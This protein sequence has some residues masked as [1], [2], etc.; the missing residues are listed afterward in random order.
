M[1]PSPLPRTEGEPAFAAVYLLDQPYAIDRAFDY[2][3][4]DL[5][6]EDIRRG[7][8]VTVP[9]GAGNKTKIGLVTG[10][11]DSTDAK[12]IKPIDDLLAGSMALDEEMTDLCLRLAETTLSTV[13]DAVRAAVPTFALGSVTEH[14]APVPGRSYS[15]ADE[16]LA[17]IYRT[18]TECGDLTVRR[19]RT[20]TGGAI[21]TAALT[22]LCRKLTR[23]GYF[24]CT[25]TP[26]AAHLGTVRR[27]YRLATDR[28]TAVLLSNGEGAGATR[29]RSSAHREILRCFLSLP[30]GTELPE[31]FFTGGEDGTTPPR[32]YSRPQL[33]ALTEKDLLSVREEVVFRDPVRPAASEPKEY[34][35]NDEQAAALGQLVRM[36]DDK[37]A[38]AA[39]LHG[40][41]GSGK[42]CVMTGILDHILGGGGGAIL[43][44]PEISLT[45][46]TLSIF[47][48]RYGEKVAVIHS[49]LSQGERYDAYRRIREG[50]ATLVI[51]TRS[52]VFAPVRNLRL[53]IMDEEQEH[54][55]KSDRDPKYHARDVARFRCARNNALLLLAS[56]TPTLETYKKALD[57]TYTLLRLTKR[58]HDVPLPEV[59]IADMK[60]EVSGQSVTP[61]GNELLREM[62]RVKKN[63]EQSLL[64]LNRRG[65][66]R[67]LSCR[68]CGKPVLC[69]NC[70][71]ALTYHT[72]K[73]TFE[74]GHLVCHLCG[75]R[76]PVPSVCPSCSSEH[77]ARLGFGTQRIEKDLSD[78][79]PDARILRMDADSTS[80]KG[81]YD[82]MLGAFRR[83]E[84][85]ILLGT[86]MV[87]KGH[88]FPDVTLVGVLNAD[89]SMFA[90]DYRAAEHTFSMLTQ[91]I[92]RA[93]RADKP[94][95][96]IIQ[97]NNPDA[98]VIRY[99]VTQDY[100]RFY[101]N[102]IRLRRELTF[103]PFCDMVLLTVTAEE[104][105]AVL[106]AAL[107]CRKE[108]DRMTAS[109]G[110]YADVKQVVFGPFEA[111]VYRMDGKYRMRLVIKC[112]LN[113]RSRALFA[114]LLRK[115]SAPVRKKPGFPA[116]GKTGTGDTPAGKYTLSVD[117]NPSSL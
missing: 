81:A 23:L 71:V 96:A 10:I 100:E 3:I 33:K 4:P 44:L 53:I 103:P 75:A 92:G 61:I 101:E 39:L 30:E 55:Y 18:A 88:D 15:G 5:L 113:R 97:T 116:G 57:G 115:A 90:D 13:G 63:G 94:G 20:E 29:L 60:R 40:V 99:A 51:G 80:E 58:Y 12:N 95:L 110:E 93:G 52:A 31:E 98:E 114:E 73:G 67:Y 74:R 28:E 83:H 43:L 64:F 46:Q 78:L 65:F 79:L 70:S 26:D 86:Q 11:K 87:T 47:C 50:K 106:S 117:F 112:V 24:T 104:E 85:D 21:P 6:R 111:P 77:L 76:L 36:A 54:T 66:N 17:A 89:A 19:L 72:D 49:G 7:S 56:A 22:A 62:F 37:K 68:S 91:V 16:T 14:F 59:R 34:Q 48:S 107:A 38:H 25:A 41:T 45:P 1:Q 35:L 82:E 105:R 27:L 2:R 69:P 109:G 108:F 102:E 84:A 32:R 9:F 42:T 8:F